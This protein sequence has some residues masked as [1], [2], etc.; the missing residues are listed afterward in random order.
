MIQAST[1][2]A[3]LA[4][5]AARFLPTGTDDFIST[6][7]FCRT[8]NMERS[9]THLRDSRAMEHVKETGHEVTISHVHQVTME[10]VRY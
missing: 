5:A 3:P 7:W 4:I 2:N 8:C 9:A 10:G 1:G 6:M